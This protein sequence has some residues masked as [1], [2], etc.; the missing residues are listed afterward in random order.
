MIFGAYST[1]RK[2]AS[3]FWTVGLRETHRAQLPQIPNSDQR[4]QP[5]IDLIRYTDH[6]MILV[7]VDS[8]RRIRALS[9]IKNQTRIKA[10]SEREGVKADSARLEAGSGCGLVIH[11]GKCW[12]RPLSIR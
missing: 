7:S 1:E 5:Q 10:R 8:C 12:D 11:P 6:L 3:I 4:D 9:K 2:E